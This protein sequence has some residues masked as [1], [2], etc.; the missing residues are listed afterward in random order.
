VTFRE[1][2]QSAAREAGA[3]IYDPHKTLCA[4]GSCL[5]QV[6]GVSI[7]KDTDH[8]AATRV[9]ILKQGLLKSLEPVPSLK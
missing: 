4:S 3:E 7:Y 5:Y 2:L 1:R 9:G 8:L 6:D